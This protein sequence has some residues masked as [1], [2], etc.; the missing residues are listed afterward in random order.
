MANTLKLP[1]T[2]IKTLEKGLSPKLNAWVDRHYMSVLRTVTSGVKRMSGRA[3][4]V[5]HACD[6]AVIATCYAIAA[7]AKMDEGAWTVDAWHAL[8][9]NKA[10]LLSYSDASRKAAG[11]EDMLLIDAPLGGEEDD[12]RAEAACVA[13]FSEEVWERSVKEMDR[14][15]FAASVYG[16]MDAVF[17]ACG[18]TPR[19]ADIYRACSLERQPVEKVMRDLDVSSNVVYV[20]CHRVQEKLAANGWRVLEE[21]GLA[22]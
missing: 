5:E 17:Q 13:Q 7:L 12:S 3:M 19:A 10:R 9:M 4:G 1:A 16:R 22:A 6:V 14:A 21:L 8:A 2:V 20:T 11:R 18:V 15:A